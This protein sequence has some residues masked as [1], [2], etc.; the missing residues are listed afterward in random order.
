MLKPDGTQAD[1]GTLPV[2][3]NAVRRDVLPARRARRWRRA[4]STASCSTATSPR[5]ARSTCSAPSPTASAPATSDAVAGNA[6]DD[7]TVCHEPGVR[8]GAELRHLAAVD[9]HHRRQTRKLVPGSER[10]ILEVPAEWLH[11]CHYGGNLEWL[12]DGTILLSTGD[13]MAATV[14]GYGQTTEPDRGQRGAHRRRTPADRRGKILRLMPDGSVPD[15]SVPGIK[16]NPFLETDADG[17]AVRDAD[18]HVVTKETK[19]PYIPEDLWGDPNDDIVAYDPY[20]YS[21][22]YKQPFRGMI[23]PYTGTAIFGEVGPDAVRARP[24]PRTARRR[25]DQRDPLRRRHQPRLAALLG[26]NDPYHEYDYEDPD[27][28][29]RVRLQQDG[30]GGPVLPPRRLRP[31]AARSAP[32]CVTSIPAAFYRADTKGPLRLPAGLRRQPDL[33]G[34]QPLTASSAMPVTQTATSSPTRPSGRSSRPRTAAN[35]HRSCADPAAAPPRSMPRSAPTGRS[36]SSSTATAST[37][38]PAASAG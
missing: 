29:A 20:V 17:V 16:A 33:H 5:P 27:C 25:G 1:V 31:V 7:V 24:Q 15:G 12:P 13:D 30:S 38:A 28:R 18:G 34:V 8:G 14:A 6:Y 3:A 4:A 37:T 2:S 19:D 21:L 9:V 35:V 32:G 26:T 36:T 11:C 22:G 23:H 10:V